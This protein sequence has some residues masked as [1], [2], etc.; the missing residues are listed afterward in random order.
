MNYFKERKMKELQMLKQLLQMFFPI[1]YLYFHS[2]T[3]HN[4]HQLNHQVLLLILVY[5]MNFNDQ[6]LRLR[7]SNA[8]VHQS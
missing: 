6:N 8:S 4:D 5:F 2:V 1:N 3:S 7:N